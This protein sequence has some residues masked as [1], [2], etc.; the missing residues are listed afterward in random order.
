MKTTGRT[1]TRPAPDTEN[2]RDERHIIVAQLPL[3]NEQVERARISRILD[4]CL[5]PLVVE[6]DEVIGGKEFYKDTEPHHRQSYLAEHLS[7]VLLGFRVSLD[8][9]SERN[10]AED[11]LALHIEMECEVFIESYMKPAERAHVTTLITTAFNKYFEDI[12]KEARY[13]GQPGAG[14]LPA[15]IYSPDQSKPAPPTPPS[16]PADIQQEG[17]GDATA[18]I[19]AAAELLS[20]VYPAERVRKALEDLA[21]DTTRET[22]SPATAAARPEVAALAS[23]AKG[24]D[25]E[26]AAAETTDRA[27]EPG[28]E[29]VEA[30]KEGDGRRRDSKPIADVLAAF[31][32]DKFADELADGTMSTQKLYRYEKLHSAFY[33]HRDELPRD[34]QDM[35]TRSEVNDRIVA[36]GKVTSAEAVRSVDRD[37]KRIA[38]ARKRGVAVRAS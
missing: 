32:R 1:P 18:R 11:I 20:T 31:I 28:Q 9:T 35:P 21:A 24:V 36:E 34:L 2:V 15:I 4:E 12:I 33:N 30:R 7:L 19:Q 37:R 5:P 3:Y 29:W 14:T 16:P 6:V 8:H 10:T 27:K 22:T 13:I 23:T 25:L 38:A 26:S 17:M